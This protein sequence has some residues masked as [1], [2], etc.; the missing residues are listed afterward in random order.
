MQQSAILNRVRN[1]TGLST[2][3][4][5]DAIIIDGIDSALKEMDAAKPL[6]VFGT[7]PTF[8]SQQD[9]ALPSATSGSPPASV[10]V[11][12]IKD[13]FFTQG[14]S[15]TFPFFDADFPITVIHDLFNVQFGGNVFESP[16]LGRVLF[17]KLKVFRSQFGTTWEVIR[18]NPAFIRLYQVP[19][20]ASTVAYLGK[21]FRTKENIEVENEEL[22]IKAVLWKSAECR[23]GSLAVTKSITQTG[24]VSF[25]PA[26]EAWEK[27]ADRWK[28]EFLGQ[29]G[30]FAG[31]LS[32]G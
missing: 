19:V 5:A 8:A 31:G 18:G 21:V 29:S 4:L 16:S 24:G 22:F 25:Q 27:L 30:A 32:I 12:D 6:L 14:I 13:L 20:E 7:F 26:I 11:Y 2:T 1:R 17:Q 9:Y 23:L 3:D 15:A 28:G 10:S